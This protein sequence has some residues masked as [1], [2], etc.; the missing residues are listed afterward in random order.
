MIILSQRASAVQKL[1]C[2]FIILSIYKSLLNNIK[3]D[4]EGLLGSPLAANQG[5]GVVYNGATNSNDPNIPL[6]DQ[7]P[8][9]T[10]AP[11]GTRTTSMPQN[12][13]NINST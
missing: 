4:H 9:L 13:Q 10:D 11:L 2:I 8:G 6:V 5:R 12:T 7:R 1:N 3:I